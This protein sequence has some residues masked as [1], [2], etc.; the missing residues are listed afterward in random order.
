MKN[1]KLQNTFFKKIAEYNNYLIN[2]FNQIK[3]LKNKFNKIIYLKNKFNQISN[4]NKFLIF[5]ISI[6]FLYLFYVSTPSLYDYQRLQNQLKTHLLNDYNLNINISNKIQYKILPSPHF[7][8][9]ESTIYRDTELDENKLAEVD[10]LKIFV[11][12]A[13]I[14]NQDKLQLKNIEIKE[15]IFFLDKDNQKFMFNYFKDKNTDKK[16]SIKKSKF[17]LMDKDEVISIFPI[18]DMNFKYNEKKFINEVIINGKAF[19]SY[20]NLDIKKSFFG[21]EDL[22]FILK[23]PQINLSVIGRILPQ[24]NN[25]DKYKI[26]N[27]VNFLGSEIKSEFD[28]EKNYLTFKSIKSKIFNNHIDFNGIVKFQPFYTTSNIILDQLNLI[29]ILNNHG[30]LP[31]FQE[32]KKL[33]HKNFN[34]K[35][36]IDVKK[37]SKA[38]IFDS[39]IFSIKTKNGLIKFA[40]SVFSA[41]KWGSLKILSSDLYINKNRIFLNS[42]ILIDVQNQKK[43]YSIFQIPKIYKKDIKKINLSFVTNLTSGTTKITDFQINNII[44]NSL[45]E[46]I[47]KVINNNNNNFNINKNF[48]NWIILKKFLNI[49]I[50]EVNQE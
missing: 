43:F 26:F 3:V 30:I 5:F 35:I 14:H 15:S 10:Y 27:K 36:T 41:K 22:N 40:D 38:N 16:I 42:Q 12:I 2:K 48:N 18:N 19:N 8:V 24:K 50:L 33:I 46:K 32:R 34:S 49:V 37:F 17:F 31:R 29:K 11:S 23:F 47:N 9:K 28:I 25:K 1:I 13:N 21:D 39:A 4:F 44:S 20:F 45:T 6:L 7:E